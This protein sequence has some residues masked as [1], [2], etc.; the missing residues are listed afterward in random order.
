MGP[1]LGPRVR[2]QQL[3]APLILGID[4]YLEDGKYVFTEAYH[5]KRGR[6]CNSGCR[7]CPYGN[8]NGVRTRAE[9]AAAAAERDGSV[10]GSSPPEE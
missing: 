6:C 3:N 4:Y 1:R 10:L 8:A 5:R 9:A 2:V 7:H